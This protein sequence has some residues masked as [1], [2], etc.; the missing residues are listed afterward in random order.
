MR[1]ARRPLD[2]KGTKEMNKSTIEPA[3]GL[4][5]GVRKV[6]SKSLTGG[7]VAVVYDD[8]GATPVAEH[9]YMALI[10]TTE[11]NPKTGVEISRNARAQELNGAILKAGQLARA[12]RIAWGLAQVSEG[13]RC[14]S[15]VRKYGVECE[16]AVKAIAN[17]PNDDARKTANKSLLA[18]SRKI[19]SE[20]AVK[21]TLDNWARANNA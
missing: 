21:Y 9:A 12:I 2:Q 10:A 8:H 20:Y 16:N 11:R 5:Y 13:S 15:I 19:E 14:T 4:K 18:L 6:A 3:R 1:G 7:W 17:A